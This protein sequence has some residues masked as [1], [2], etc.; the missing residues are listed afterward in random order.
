MHP[1]MLKSSDK[2]ICK[3]NIPDP[4][5]DVDMDESRRSLKII[6]GMEMVYDPMMKTLL[7][8]KERSHRLSRL[9]N[10]PQENSKILLYCGKIEVLLNKI[11]YIHVDSPYA[12]VFLDSEIEKE[13]DFR[14]NLQQIET[15][16][17]KQSLIRSHRSYL[18]NPDK[19][20]FAEKKGIRD[21]QLCFKRSQ[22]I[23]TIPL[24]RS[25]IGK[26]VQSYPF[27]FRE[28]WTASH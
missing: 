28:L 13:I 7:E 10:T 15:Y 1:K 6:Q 11:L 24:S 5:K 19:V 23:F 26:F 8:E 22:M 2:F 17:D 16:F 4:P 20:L 12:R 18:I 14:L 27:W 25:N 3:L 21:Y 9:A